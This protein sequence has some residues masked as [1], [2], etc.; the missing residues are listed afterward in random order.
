MGVDGGQGPALASGAEAAGQ[1]ACTSFGRWGIAF[2]LSPIREQGRSEARPAGLKT[3]RGAPPGGPSEEGMQCHM[4]L[5]SRGL[6]QGLAFLCSLYLA[7]S[8]RFWLP[9]SFSQLLQGPS[10][11]TPSRTQESG[12]SNDRHTPRQASLVW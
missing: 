7:G 11:Q 2:S 6:G 8:R 3:S 5:A 1:R 12:R 10:S 9:F 4:Q